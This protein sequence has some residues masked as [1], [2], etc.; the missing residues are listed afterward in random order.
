M[1]GL[2]FFM[3]VWSF[4]SLLVEYQLVA[5]VYAHVPALHVKVQKSEA[6]PVPP[7]TDAEAEAGID[8]DDDDPA[9]A[10][11]TTDTDSAAPPAVVPVQQVVRQA[12][13]V[14]QDAIMYAQAI[15]VTLQ[16]T[17]D[18]QISAVAPSAT[19]PFASYIY[20]Y[21][22]LYI[23]IYIYIYCWF[24]SLFYLCVFFHVPVSL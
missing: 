9:P 2:Q 4:F 20:L 12:Q 5:R 23:Y 21:I 19:S 14:L 15:E 22:Y 1:G 3:G 6:A 18:G 8:D 17:A 24:I 11:D 10:D 7:A 13:H 16:M